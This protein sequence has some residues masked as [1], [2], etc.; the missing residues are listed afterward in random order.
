M[1]WWDY[2]NPFTYLG[3]AAG[4]IVADGWT[5][6]MLGIWNA[7][8]WL[9]KLV[10]GIED[11]FLTPDLSENGP[12]RGIYPYTFWIAGSIILTLLMI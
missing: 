12:M 5:A 2:L 9:L 6:A 7:G 3:N 4:K 8:L 11:D 10:L 1:N